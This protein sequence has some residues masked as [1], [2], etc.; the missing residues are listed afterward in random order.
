MYEGKRVSVVLGGGGMKG[1]AHVGVLKVLAKY[2]IEPDEYIGTSVGSL[3]GALAAGGLS[4]EQVE[5][6]ALNV[7]REDILD[8]NWIGLL[9]KR[10]RASST[11]RGRAIHD[12]VRRVLP[13]DR[14]DQMKKPLYVTSV[15]LHTGRE[16]VWGMPE[17]R[18]VPVH[19]CVVASCAIPG[20]FP[21][22]KILRYSFVD[23]SI[24]DTLP[25]KVAVY[26]K[27]EI[28]IASY[29]QSQ[30][31]FRGKATAE[32]GIASV[33]E[34]ALSIW[35]RTLT[36]HNLNYFS[37]FP[38][39]LIEPHVWNHGMFEFRRTAEVIAAGVT[40]AETTLTRHPLFPKLHPSGPLERPSLE[41]LPRFL[42]ERYRTFGDG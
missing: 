32:A 16:V 42:D 27:A 17:F 31:S 36:R 24:V 14:F 39:A 21:P 20:V 33:F 35:S 19:D 11:N 30:Q 4:P 37:N 38:I 29:L 18:E 6:V 7:H 25:V 34:Q 8:W 22:K 10:G 13:V 23:G 28:I 5:E 15:D 9:W 2:G 26:N 3:I 1:I 12:F 41:D 40:A